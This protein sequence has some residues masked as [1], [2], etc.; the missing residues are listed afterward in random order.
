MS[1]FSAE[2]S[3]ITIYRKYIPNRRTYKNSSLLAVNTRTIKSKSIDISLKVVK[4]RNDS[5]K[6]P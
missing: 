2:C 6:G 3:L 1:C 5:G 4:Y